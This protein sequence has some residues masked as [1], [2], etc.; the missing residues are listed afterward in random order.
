MQRLI[1]TF[2]VSL[3][4]PLFVNGPAQQEGVRTIEEPRY[5]TMIDDSDV[6]IALLEAHHAMTIMAGDKILSGPIWAVPQVRVSVNRTEMVEP[7]PIRRTLEGQHDRAAYFRERTDIYQKLALE[8]LR[9]FLRFFKYCRAHV[10]LPDASA[11]DMTTLTWT[12]ETGQELPSN[13]ALPRVLSLYGIELD[14][15]VGVRALAVADDPALQQ[16][17]AEPPIE[18]ELYEELL[19]DA[20]AALFQGSLRRAILELAI[21]CE[22]AIKQAFFDK[23]TEAALSMYF[24]ERRQLRD[25]VGGFT[26][27]L[28]EPAQQILG[29]NFRKTEKRACIHIDNLFQCR[30]QI[31]HEGQPTYKNKRGRLRTLDQAVAKEWFKAADRLFHWLRR[32]QP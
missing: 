18:P 10:L 20:R 12:D 7:P 4:S 29:Q 25:S 30:N 19:S 3:S 1:A 24:D 2:D 6:E 17:L 26:N 32:M 22:V 23:A 8:A 15:E 21:S 27:L 31:A 14:E 28:S 13:V 16:A 5:A 9:R 11:A